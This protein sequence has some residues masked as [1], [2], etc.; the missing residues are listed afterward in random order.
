M[1]S[2]KRFFKRMYVRYL[3]VVRYQVSNETNKLTDNERITKTICMKLINHPLSKFLIAPLS[4]KRYIKN[5]SLNI[6]VVLDDKRVSITNHVY[7]YDVTIP[8]REFD[9]LALMFDNKTENIRQS[10]E[11]DMK[12]QI[13]HSLSTILTKISNL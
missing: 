11:N 3:K 4:G 13:V 7:H 10:F 1:M 2:V 5:E 12:S 9:R 8:Q 6:F